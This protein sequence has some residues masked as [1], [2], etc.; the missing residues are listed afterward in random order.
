MLSSM[1][2]PTKLTRPSNP[3]LLL[4]AGCI[5]GISIG[6]GISKFISNIQA[7]TFN[8]P[9]NDTRETCFNDLPKVI[10]YLQRVI[11]KRQKHIND[12]KSKQPVGWGF[13]PNNNL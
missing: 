7:N 8:N 2:Y 10:D 3:F 6:F 4:T 13:Y 1:L 9:E 5:L 11:N 12:L